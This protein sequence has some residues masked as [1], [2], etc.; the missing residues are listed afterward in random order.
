MENLYLIVGLG[1]PGA[2]YAETRHN[3]GFLLVEQLAAQW[4]AEWANE[5]KFDARVAQ[6]GTRR[7]ARYVV[8]AADVHERERRGGGRAGGFLS[9]AAEADCWW[10]WTT[11]ICR[12]AKSG[13][14]PAAAA[15]GIMG[16]SRS[17]STWRR[18]NLR[19]CG[20]ASGGKD[21]EREITDYVLGRFDS[22]R[23][24]AV[25]KSFGPR[26]PARWNAGWTPELKKQ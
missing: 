17:S 2:E 12:W 7:Q 26:R 5:R 11:R 3:V 18:G 20:S 13:C 15:A 21:G 9:V 19:G 25:G 8:R 10:R 14:G 4:K 23:K 22:R 16:W 1:N 24:R 6:G